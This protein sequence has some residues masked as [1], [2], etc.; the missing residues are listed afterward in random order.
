MNFQLISR[1][2]RTMLTGKDNMSYDFARVGGGLAILVYLGLAIANWHRFNPTTFG[3]GFGV[4]VSGVG[5]LLGLKSNTE[6]GE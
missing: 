2:F 3:A 4:M 1:V 5:V 6:P